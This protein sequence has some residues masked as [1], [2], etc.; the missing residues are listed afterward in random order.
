MSE[1]D[2]FDISDDDSGAGSLSDAYFLQRP[3]IASSKVTSHSLCYSPTSPVGKHP[4]KL[5]SVPTVSTVPTNTVK[6]GKPPSITTGNVFYQGSGRTWWHA[7]EYD[8]LYDG[9]TTSS[10][11]S[12]GASSE[13]RPIQEDEPD[14][15]VE[16]QKVMGSSLSTDPRN[17][18]PQRREKRR[19]RQL[20]RKQMEQIA[21]EQAVKEVRGTPQDSRECHD[22]I[23]AALFVAQLVLVV[24]CAIKFGSGSDDLA[25]RILSSQN[26][27]DDSALS[28]FVSDNV[29]NTTTHQISQAARSFVL[30]YRTVMSIVGITGFYACILS[31]VTVGFMLIIAKSLIETA[32]IFCILLLLAWGVVGVSVEPH[33]YL[34][35]SMG[36]VALFLLIGYTV[37]VWDRIPF[38]S[39]NLNTALNAMRSSADITLL[40]MFMLLVSF[41]WCLVWCMAF[42]GI[43]DTLNECEPG[44]M[45]CRNQRHGH[46]FLVI[47]FFF[48]FYW[49]N[50]VITVSIVNWLAWSLSFVLWCSL[51]VHLVS[52]TEHYKGNSCQCSG[53]LVVSSGRNESMLFQI[54]HESI[55][56]VRD[57]VVGLHLSRELGGYT[58]TTYCRLVEDLLSTRHLSVSTHYTSR[59]LLGYVARFLSLVTAMQSM[60]LFVH[61]HVRLYVCRRR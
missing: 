53:Y 61:W 41:S 30:N 40:G 33:H 17:L 49:T 20:R 1:D 44:D 58:R 57:N 29:K 5:P 18:L 10:R 27:D 59:W 3:D 52:I 36:F 45:S 2:V 47:M 23:F 12:Y 26:S 50:V 46:V 48:S 55:S 15:F 38:S 24:F 25:T 60:V 34:V 56:A 32:L 19:L 21:R 9:V 22:S 13:F 31:L 4:S 28:Q 51:H 6:N 37:V 11:H 42:I 16:E 54:C 39:A 43:V 14:V 8:P 7:S 35:P